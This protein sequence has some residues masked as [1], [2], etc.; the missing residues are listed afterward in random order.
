MVLDTKNFIMTKIT[1]D[2]DMNAICQMKLMKNVV[3]FVFR[4]QMLALSLSRT[5][6][7]QNH[8]E[9]YESKYSLNTKH[10]Q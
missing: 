3:V 6:K 1:C 5:V 8:F 7:A 2:F 4:H 10:A 9:L